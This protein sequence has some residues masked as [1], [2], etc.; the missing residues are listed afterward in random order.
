[1][2]SVV[3]HALSHVSTQATRVEVH[4]SDTNGGKGG[5]ADIHWTL[6]ARVEG[7]PP[8]VV[9]DEA[10]TLEL[11]VTGAAGKLKRAVE[12]VV[13][14]RQTSDSVLP[15]KCLPISGTSRPHLCGGPCQPD[16]ADQQ[17]RAVVLG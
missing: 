12:S 9:S 5:P 14:R 1:M 17:P 10:A 13:E 7:R 8:T 16:G 2:Q 11:A 4:A 6:E 15:L 3:E